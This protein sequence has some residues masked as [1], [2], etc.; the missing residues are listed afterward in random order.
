MLQNNQKLLSAVSALL[1]V[2]SS[3]QSVPVKELLAAL[4]KSE[5]QNARMREAIAFATAPD[6]WIQRED[7]VY[8]YRYRDWYVDVLSQALEVSDEEH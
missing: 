8:E 2:L 1:P 6:M 7:D 5:K 3:T 4:E